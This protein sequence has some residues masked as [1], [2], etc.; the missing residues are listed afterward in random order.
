METIA[1]V[2]DPGL[3]S[4]EARKRKEYMVDLFVVQAKNYDFHDDI[5]GLYAHRFWIRTMVRIVEKFM[6]NR[7]RADMLDMG[8]GTGFV[9]FNVARKMKNI[10]IESFD[11]S[12]DMIAVAKERYEK[13]FKGRNIKFWVADAEQPFGENKYDIVTTSFAYRNFANKNLATKNVFNALKPGG[14]FIIQDLTKPEKQPMKGLYAFYMKYILPVLARI[15]GTEKTAAGWLKKSTDMMPSNAQIQKILEEAGMV[16][17][18]YKSLS[19]GIA[20][21]IVGF[22][23]EA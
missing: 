23:P 6:K 7:E 3:E 17:C 16:N 18:Y 11:L 10:D 1:P 15:L 13:G 9:T 8:C 4:E 14:I 22:K 20:C 19:A 12:P 21:I 2:K 5:Y